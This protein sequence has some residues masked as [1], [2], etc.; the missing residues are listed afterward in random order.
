MSP[1]R[2]ATKLTYIDARIPVLQDVPDKDADA[3]TLKQHAVKVHD[4]RACH[5]YDRI[6]QV[7][8]WCFAPDLL[9]TDQGVRSGTYKWCSERCRDAAA[10]RAKQGLGQSRS[11]VDSSK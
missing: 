7:C 1:R 5:N 11:G 10:A 9:F 4:I 8:Y 2:R 3:N 6:T